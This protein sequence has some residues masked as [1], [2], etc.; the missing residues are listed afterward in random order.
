VSAIIISVIGTYI[1][2]SRKD[3]RSAV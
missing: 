3:M 2:Y 1:L